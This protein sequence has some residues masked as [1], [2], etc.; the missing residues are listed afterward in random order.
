MKFNVNRSMSVGGNSISFSFQTKQ[1]RNMVIE[2]NEKTQVIKSLEISTMH[3]KA[4]SFH[5]LD[6]VKTYPYFLPLPLLGDS[7]QPINRHIGGK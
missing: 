7:G 3:I 4:K 6:S 2:A 1:K 5:F